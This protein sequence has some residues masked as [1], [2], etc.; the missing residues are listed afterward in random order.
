LLFISIPRH[1][2]IAP[3]TFKSELLP[4]AEMGVFRKHYASDKPLI[5]SLFA[6]IEIG[7]EVFSKKSAGIPSKI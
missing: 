4:T 5:T 2:A 6:I 1:Y 3:G 7:V